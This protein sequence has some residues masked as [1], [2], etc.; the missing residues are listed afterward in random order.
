LSI[1][2]ADEDGRVRDDA[3]VQQQGN[4]EPGNRPESDRDQAQQRDRDEDQGNRT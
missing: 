3:G 1:A 2:L 4:R